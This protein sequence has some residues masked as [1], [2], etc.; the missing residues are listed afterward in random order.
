MMEIRLAF[1]ALFRGF[2][3]QPMQVSSEVT[4]EFA[5]TM[6]PRGFRCKIHQ[7]DKHV[8]QAIG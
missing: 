1:T 8:A 6:S 4:E 2:T 3:L 5:F 7:R